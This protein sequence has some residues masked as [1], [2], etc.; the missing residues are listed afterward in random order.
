MKINAVY[1][2]LKVQNVED[3]IKRFN[4]EII[5]YQNLYKTVIIC[6]YI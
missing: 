3:I 6:N 5:K 1:H 4:E 2:S